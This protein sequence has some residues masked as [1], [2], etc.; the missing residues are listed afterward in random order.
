MLIGK[1][2]GR[3]EGDYG[4]PDVRKYRKKK[5]RPKMR[6]GDDGDSQRDEQRCEEQ[7]RGTTGSHPEKHACRLTVKLR[8]RTEAPGHGAEGGQFLSARG[9]KPQAP[10]GPLQRLLGALT[11]IAALQQPTRTRL[12]KQES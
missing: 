7:Q 10:H 6:D 4:R 8:G 12:G 2:L 11:R 3:R 1:S 5:C 9:A